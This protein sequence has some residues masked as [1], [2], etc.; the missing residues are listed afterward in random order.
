MLAALFI[1]TAP[2][3]RAATTVTIPIDNVT[4]QTGATITVTATDTIESADLYQYSVTGTCQG[5]GLLRNYILPENFE[6]L[7]SDIDPK[8]SLVPYVAG[9]VYDVDGKFPFLCLKRHAAG[10]FDVAVGR[11][12]IPVRGSIQVKAGINSK[13]YCYITISGIKF[14]ADGF[15]IRNPNDGVQLN[16]QCVVTVASQA[17]G[18]QPNLSIHAPPDYLRGPVIIGGTAGQVAE[19]GNLKPNHTRT[20]T[21]YLENQGVATDSFIISNPVDTGAT[22]FTQKFFLGT[23]NVTEAIT[24]GTF[25]IDNLKPGA[26]KSLKWEITNTSAPSGSGDGTPILQAAS[27]TDSTRTDEVGFYLEAP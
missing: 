11:F 25:E 19:G 27:V 9:T 6:Q 26:S 16:G 2:A 18:P 5:V 20:A 7:L 1:I 22:G 12:E 3:G 21:V 10:A 17:G 24:S 14:A 8:H 13:G 15:V 4:L 23:D